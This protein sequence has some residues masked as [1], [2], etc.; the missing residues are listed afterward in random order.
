MF[1]NAPLQDL[2][3]GL[4]PG[5]KQLPVRAVREK[6]LHAISRSPIQISSRIVAVAQKIHHKR[7]T[8]EDEFLA[9]LKKH[10]IEFDPKYVFG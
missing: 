4:L 6:G 3:F 2:C 8:F 5:S 7:M 9:L 10:K 1:K